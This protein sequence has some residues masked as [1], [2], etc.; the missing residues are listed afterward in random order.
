MVSNVSWVFTSQIEIA[1]CI[2]GEDILSPQRELGDS[3]SECGCSAEPLLTKTTFP[4]MLLWRRKA[5]EGF[6]VN[7]VPLASSW[8]AVGLGLVRL[9]GV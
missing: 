2:F 1:F 5:V 9:E 3:S 8:K 6:L 4:N 7:V